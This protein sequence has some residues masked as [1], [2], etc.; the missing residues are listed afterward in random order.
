MIRRLRVRLGVL[1]V[2]FFKLLFICLLIIFIYLFIFFAY[3]KIRKVLTWVQARG[4]GS[5]PARVLALVLARVL[6][7]VLARILAYGVTNRA[8]NWCHSY[9]SG[10]RQLVCIDG[11]ESSLA[12]VN[13]GVPQRSILGPL[14]FILFIKDL[15]LYIT[16]QRRGS[17]NP[18][19]LYP[20][21]HGGGMTLRVRPRVQCVF[22]S[23]YI[24]LRLR[25]FACVL[26]SDLE[27]LSRSW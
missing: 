6:A 26:K 9:L 12:C 5:S 17:I 16:M 25:W 13:H 24:V 19:P 18:R 15:P 14:F 4:P 2:A 23:Q 11:K 10:R 20:L 21:Y 7:L 1:F 3:R 22:S 8:Y 27:L